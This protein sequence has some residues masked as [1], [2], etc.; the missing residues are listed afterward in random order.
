MA[1]RRFPPPWTVED[2]GASFVVRD[3]AGQALAYVYY[4]VELARRSAANPLTKDEARRIA[5]N[6]ARLPK[7]LHERPEFDLRKIDHHQFSEYI[8][9]GP[10]S[11]AEVLYIEEC[12]D[13]AWLALSIAAL[14]NAAGWALSAIPP[15]PLR[16]E[17]LSVASAVG[18][19]P[20]GITVLAKKP[21]SFDVFGGDPFNTVYFAIAQSLGGTPDLMAQV[22]ENLPDGFVRIIVAP[23]A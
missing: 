15:M 1:E 8:A 17:N 16:K 10:Q 2:L 18:V 13:C 22:D 12:P 5:V 7:L 23:S 9:R 11:R 20:R 4:E 21:T 6:I 19:L 3:D 14:L